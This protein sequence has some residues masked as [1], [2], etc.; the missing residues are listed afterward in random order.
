MTRGGP[1]GQLP[2][3]GAPRPFALAGIYENT[4]QARP[5]IRWGSNRT[6]ADN[7]SRTRRKGAAP[8]APFR[9]TE[10]VRPI[11]TQPQS[12]SQDTEALSAGG[13]RPRRGARAPRR[14][15]PRSA[16]GRSRGASLSS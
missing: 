16:Q 12:S 10:S 13:R 3:G 7:R 8:A 5:P 2:T 6:P 1:G 14:A 11:E 9:E 15:A 4:L